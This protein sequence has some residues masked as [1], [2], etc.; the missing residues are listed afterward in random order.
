M[1]DVDLTKKVRTLLVLFF[2]HS[3]TGVT[4]LTAFPR[5]NFWEKF[6]RRTQVPV[7]NRLEEH[8]SWGNFSKEL[9]SP[10]SRNLRGILS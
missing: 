1:I 4:C 9:C 7:K 6:P 3:N 2:R 10:K 8:S 5:R